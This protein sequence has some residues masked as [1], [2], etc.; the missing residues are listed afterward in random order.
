MKM[1][2]IIVLLLILFVFNV[3]ANREQGCASPKN[4]RHKNMRQLCSKGIIKLSKRE[5]HDKSKGRAQIR[6]AGDGRIKYKMGKHFSLETQCEHYDARTGKTEGAT[7]TLCPFYT[8]TEGECESGKTLTPKDELATFLRSLKCGCK[9][10][11]NI[12]NDDVYKETS[13]SEI[14]KLLKNNGTCYPNTY[15]KISFIGEKKIFTPEEV[16]KLNCTTTLHETNLCQSHPAYEKCSD[17]ASI[18]VAASSSSMPTSI[19]V[20]TSSSS[21]P[22]SQI[23]FLSFVLSM[24]KGE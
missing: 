3:H 11:H 14:N 18:P 21:T 16:K 1:K 22:A 20:T 6:T 8:L 19:P 15:V 7:T 5:K 12:C 23:L 17:N 2:L 9:K 13:F 4:I 10:R 24:L